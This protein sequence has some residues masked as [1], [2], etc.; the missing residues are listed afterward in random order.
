MRL[1]PRKRSAY[2]SVLV[3]CKR[4]PRSPSS[5]S[6]I[7]RESFAAELETS[8]AVSTDMINAPI[9][10]TATTPKTQTKKARQ[11]CGEGLAASSERRTLT[12]NVTDPPK[13]NNG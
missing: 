6:F 12:L 9:T 7:A 13:N 1:N 5:T 2:S 11:S 10:H 3:T 8:D 4:T